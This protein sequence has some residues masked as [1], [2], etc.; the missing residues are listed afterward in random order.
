M[1]ALMTRDIDQI[2]LFDGVDHAHRLSEKGFALAIVSSNSDKCPSRA[3][4]PRLIDDYACGASVFGKLR[5]S[6]RCR[7]RNAGQHAIYI[8]DEIRDFDAAKDAGSSLALRGFTRTPLHSPTLIFRVLMTL[9]PS[10][11]LRGRA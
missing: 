6:G 5:K 8:G 9:R 4:P 10:W 7:R 3:G 2:H 1:R 11:R